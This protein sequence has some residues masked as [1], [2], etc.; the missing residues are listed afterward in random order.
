MTLD[1]GLL[2]YVV[3]L[4]EYG[5]VVNVELL[6]DAG[7]HP[8]FTDGVSARPRSR[9]SEY[10]RGNDSTGASDRAPEESDEF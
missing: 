5:D 2:K 10:R 9:P 6:K 7:G 8:D 4:D 3:E 1:H